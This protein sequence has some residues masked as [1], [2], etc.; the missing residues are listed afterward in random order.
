MRFA[1]LGDHNDGLAMAR[2]LVETGRH[3]L[4]VYAGPAAGVE[5][6]RRWNLAPERLGDLE[7][8]LADPSIAAVIVA[9]SPGNRLG[10]LRRALQSERHVL[11]VHPLAS[12]P[13]SA[14]E[15]AMMQADVGCFLIPLL[16]EAL[17]PGVRRLLTVTNGAVAASVPRM[18]QREAV[19]AAAPLSSEAIAAALMQRGT[20]THPVAATAPFRLLELERWSTDAVLLDAETPGH[21]PGLPGWDVLRFLGGEIV[22]VT[23]LAAHEEVSGAEPLVVT[24]CFALGGLF[25]MTLLPRQSRDEWRLAAL[26]AEGRAELHFADGWPGPARLT[27][28]DSGG[29][30][31]AEEFEAWNPWT[32]LVEVVEARLEKKGTQL[33]SPTWQDAVRCMELDDAARRSVERRR[34]S[35]LEYQEASEEASFK[36]TMTLVGCGL[37]WISLLL[38]ILSVWVPWLGWFIAPVFAIFLIM[39]LLRWVVPPMNQD[40]RPDSRGSKTRPAA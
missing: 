7:E 36:G 38:V 35:T 21:A 5:Y 9:G 32:A 13:D 12:R 18:P 20:S 1:L 14:Y 11:C 2:A 26:T 23:A 28:L 30:E 10:L 37:L 6:L 4:A 24:G 29:I 15:A 16:P 33:F 27:Y 25:H 22:E 31:Q 40:Q 39:Q 19:T 8:V 17:H 3:E 34:T